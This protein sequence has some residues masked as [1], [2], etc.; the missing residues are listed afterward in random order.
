MTL[1]DLR[2]KL[3]QHIAEKKLDKFAIYGKLTLLT[4]LLVPRITASTPSTPE[5]VEKLRAALVTVL[6]VKL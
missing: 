2:T 3:D 6:G 4:G 5:Q 1:F